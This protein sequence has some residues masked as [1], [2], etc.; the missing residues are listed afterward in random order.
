MLLAAKLVASVGA[1]GFFDE[2]KLGVVFFDDGPVGVV[3]ADWSGDL[4]PVGKFAEELDTFVRVQ[5]LSDAA[6]NAGIVVD[7]YVIVWRSIFQL[8]H[9]VES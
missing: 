4:E 3:I 5:L 6:F 1:L 7:H 9:F 2:I 8:L